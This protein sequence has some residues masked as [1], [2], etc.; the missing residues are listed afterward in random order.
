LKINEVL[1]HFSGVRESGDEWTALCPAHDDH[2]NS[3]SIGEGTDGKFLLHCH[4]GC[5]ILTVAEAAGLT[6]ADLRPSVKPKG[7]DL[8]SYAEAKRL[9]Q[10]RLES[11]FG[12][13]DVTYFDDGR[14][15]PALA[16]PYADRS[17]KSSVGV[18]YRIDLHGKDRFRWKKGSKAKGMLYGL[19]MLDDIEDRGFVVIVEG[20][21]DCHAAWENDIPALGVPGANNWAETNCALLANVPMIYVVKEPDKGGETLVAALS[22]SGLS[23]RVRVVHLSRLGFNDISEM[24]VDDPS[25]F[26]NRWHEVVEKHTEMLRDEAIIPAVSP[27]PNGWAGP[28]IFGADELMAKKLP[29]PRRAIEGLLPEG[30]TILGGKPK[31]GKSWVCLGLGVAIS[32]GGMA[33]GAVPVKEGEVLYLALEDSERRLQERLTLVLAGGKAPEGFKFATEWP[34]LADGG[35]AL[36]ADWLTEHPACRLVIVDTLQKVR[37]PARSGANAYADDYSVLSPI[38]ELADSHR[39]PIVVVHHLRKEGADDP[40]DQ[41]SGTTGLTGAADTLISLSREKETVDAVLYVRGRDVE[42]RQLALQWDKELTA[43]V[44]VGESKDFAKT[45]HRGKVVALAMEMG[46]IH[47]VDVV[48]RFGMSSDAARQLLRRMF[49]D[50]ELVRVGK[51]EYSAPTRPASVTSQGHSSVA[52]MPGDRDVVTGVTEDPEVV[53]INQRSAIALERFGRLRLDAPMTSDEAEELL[54]LLCGTG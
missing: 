29:E 10:E 36:L 51:G 7:C 50:E 45:H 28:L 24:H 18:R 25:R 9:D 3:L 44:L 19:W 21:S 34:L 32:T 12:L 6:I 46:S 8:K 31:V 39:V 16:I 20:E 2:H 5:E 13:S 48:E 17:G 27:L 47:A 1:E 35:L 37:V 33:L 38:K 52:P 53:P 4:A 49:R 54:E 11:V 26:A 40:L 14:T 22:S 23:D 42:E 30:L 43:W 41:F 15:L